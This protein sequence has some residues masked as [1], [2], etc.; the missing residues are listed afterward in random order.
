MCS[1]IIPSGGGV[2]HAASETGY[3]LPVCER[4]PVTGGLTLSFTTTNVVD[5][6]SGLDGAY[7][8]ALDPQSR[9]AYVGCAE[10]SLAAFEVGVFRD[11]FESGD[12]S[13][14]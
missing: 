3:T 7:S 2:S 6:G 10:N 11:G 1:I 8:L 9:S 5:G 13:A 4:D 12:Q 14:R